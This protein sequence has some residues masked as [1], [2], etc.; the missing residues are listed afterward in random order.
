M[1]L[2]LIN[3]SKRGPCANQSKRQNVD[4]MLAQVATFHINFPQVFIV[5]DFKEQSIRR[6]MK[7]CVFRRLDK[8]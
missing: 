1:G 4:L 3:F 5:Y 6:L 8:C 7:S 2:K